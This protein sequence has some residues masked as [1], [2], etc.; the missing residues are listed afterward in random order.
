LLVRIQSTLVAVEVKTRVGA[1]PRGA[2]T[3]DKADHVWAAISGLRPRPQQLDLVT[4]R[5]TAAGADIRWIPK[6]R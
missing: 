3:A 5:L 2:Y 6:V 4:V 1:D